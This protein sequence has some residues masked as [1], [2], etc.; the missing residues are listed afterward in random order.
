MNSGNLEYT[1]P[2]IQTEWPYLVSGLGGMPYT[3]GPNMAHYGHNSSASSMMPNSFPGLHHSAMTRHPRYPSSTA[4]LGSPFTAVSQGAPDYYPN[5]GLS[6]ALVESY[7]PGGQIMNYSGAG[8]EASVLTNIY[9]SIEN[10]RQWALSVPTCRGTSRYEL[11]LASKYPTVSTSFNSALS[12]VS[13]GCDSV[14]GFPAM[15]SLANSLPLASHG[16]RALPEPKALAAL[17]GGSSNHRISSG[18]HQLSYPAYT[19]ATRISTPWSSE[20]EQSGRGEDPGTCNPANTSTI[21]GSEH[22][23]TSETEESALGLLHMSRNSPSI[24]ENPAEYSTTSL[25]GSTNRGRHHTPSSP[26]VYASA[27]SVLRSQSQQKEYFVHDLRSPKAGSSTA[28]FDGTIINSHHAYSTFPQIQQPHHAIHRT[29]SIDLHHHSSAEMIS[30]S[31]PRSSI[32]SAG[33]R[34]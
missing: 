5:P 31:T 30:H 15:G 16:E 21:A 10:Q 6:E 20:H 24:I 22:K 28:T 9:D 2:P 13:T 25:S 3:L 18:L 33:G 1:T 8:Q 17:D 26:S 29:P 12:A 27:E 11:D 34:R 19:P 4:C 23:T 32:S 14:A 7:A